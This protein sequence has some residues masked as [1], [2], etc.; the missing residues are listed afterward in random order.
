M[1]IDFRFQTGAQFEIK[2]KP[3]SKRAKGRTT[4]LKSGL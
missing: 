3:T 2:I 1:Q 4:E